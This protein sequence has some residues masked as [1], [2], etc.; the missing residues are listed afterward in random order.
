MHH[1]VCKYVAVDAKVVVAHHTRVPPALTDIL[2]LLG[3]LVAQRR[4]G[5]RVFLLVL[6]LAFRHGRERVQ[7]RVAR[8]RLVRVAPRHLDPVLERKQVVV[9]AGEVRR[10]NQ[11]EAA[12]GALRGQTADF[13]PAPR[14]QVALTAGVVV[15]CAEAD[16]VLLAEPWLGL[17]LALDSRLAAAAARDSLGFRPRGKAHHQQA[18]AALLGLERRGWRCAGEKELAEVLLVPHDR[19]AGGVAAVGARAEL[20]ADGDLCGEADHGDAYAVL[21]EVVDGVV[22]VAGVAGEEGAV[23]YEDFAGTV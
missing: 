10:E 5:R 23:Y 4:L 11:R 22:D 21:D 12:G 2:E 16:G 14:A 6:A 9:R 13:G 3:L 7:T 18:G 1:L 17:L 19:V 8:D 20:G 15:A